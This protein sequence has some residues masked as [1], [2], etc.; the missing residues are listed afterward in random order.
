[1]LEIIRSS[2]KKSV[3]KLLQARGSAL[4]A[5][6]AVVRPILDDIRRRGDR[7]LLGYAKKFDRLDLR[8]TGFTVSRAEI[9]R[10]YREVP[11]GFVEAVRV[12]AA[13]IRKTARR[14]LP[15]AWTA[16]PRAGISVGQIIR[17]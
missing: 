7:A 1:M 15:Q 8:K 11:Q 3:S 16:E 5:A 6:E 2:D 12:A 10:A 13:N 4:S 17:P 14:Q 9:R